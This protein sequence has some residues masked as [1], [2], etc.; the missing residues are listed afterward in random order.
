MQKEVTS[1]VVKG[2]IIALLLIVLD[3]VIKVMGLGTETLIGLIP[4]LIFLGA[5]IWG[6]IIYGVQ[7]EH[8]VTFGKLFMH[9]FKMS[10]VVACLVF[11]YTVLSVYVIFP[12]QL[13]Q[14][15]EKAMEKARSRP[16]YNEEQMQQ[17]ME[18]G[19]KIM[20]VTVLVGSLLGTLVVGVIGALIGAAA[21][22]KRPR[23]D[24]EN[25]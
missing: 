21:G 20:T 22:K 8:N 11:V 19:R 23:P 7:M 4:T 12:E 16:D 25:V 5:I 6:T 17:G 2:L 18:I 14:M 1:H 13:D 15:W 9:G 3:I 24:F 10:A